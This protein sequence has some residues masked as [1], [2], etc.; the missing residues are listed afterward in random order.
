MRKAIFAAAVL[1]TVLFA[2]KRRDGEV[3]VED[4]DIQTLD[5]YERLPI[6]LTIA[7]I[8]AA[9]EDDDEDDF[10]PYERLPMGYRFSDEEIGR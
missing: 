6:G 10:D 3:E 1:A 2:L 8:E 9:E 5:P 7:D 4:I